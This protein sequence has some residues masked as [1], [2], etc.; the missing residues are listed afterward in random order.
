MAD[1]GQNRDFSFSKA[2]FQGR[3]RPGCRPDSDAPAGKDDTGEGT[4]A[5]GI[6]DFNER[7]FKGKTGLL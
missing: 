6:I 7:Y 2:F 1:A 3:Y 5:D 4:A